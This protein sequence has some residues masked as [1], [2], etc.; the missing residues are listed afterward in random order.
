MNTTSQI[1]RKKRGRREK[2][3]IIESDDEKIDE[4]EGLRDTNQNE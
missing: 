4:N 3:T 1:N 2:K